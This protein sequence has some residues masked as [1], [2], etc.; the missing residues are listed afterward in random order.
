MHR[1]YPKVGFTLEKLYLLCLTEKKLQVLEIL[2][3]L[4][5]DIKSLTI[6]LTS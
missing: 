3:Y 6:T 4:L 1:N 5:I 2:L